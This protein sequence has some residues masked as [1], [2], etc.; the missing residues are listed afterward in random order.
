MT[1]IEVVK[2]LTVLVLIAVVTVFPWN[3]SQAQSTKKS[4]EILL[5]GFQIGKMDVEE[6]KKGSLIEYNLKSLVSFWFFG[7]INVDLSIKSIYKDG[8]M[9]SS[10][11]K[12]V[13]NRGSFYSNIKWNGKSY[14]VDSHTYEFDNN[15]A[16]TKPIPFS[17]VK[18]YFQEPM[19]GLT[20]V[21]ETYGLTSLISELES[22]TYRIE[23]DGNK[24]KFFYENGEMEKAL[25][26]SPIKN[27]VIKRI[28]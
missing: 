7:K 15:R 11:S 19:N 14:D 17:T 28:R 25:M 10:E 3:E 23:I 18:F 8:M 13:S 12:S 6:L 9:L 20:M 24:N 21:S 4:Y 27:Y 22:K 16:I 1:K 26:E 2:K 5:A